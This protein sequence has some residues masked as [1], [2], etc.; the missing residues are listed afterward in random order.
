MKRIALIIVALAVLSA[1][2]EFTGLTDRFVSLFD[3]TTEYIKEI[4]IQEVEVSEKETRIE[5]AQNAKLKEVEMAA[6]AAYDNH[7]KNAM[8]EIR[9]TVLKEMEGEFREE[10][11]AAEKE[12]GVY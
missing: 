7:Y 4:E 9:A 6:Q 2:A 3:N 1:T 11:T 12:I 8:T 10:R 5:A